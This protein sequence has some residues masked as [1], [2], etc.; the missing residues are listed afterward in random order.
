VPER[1]IISY[2][3]EPAGF[4][5]RVY[6]V[7]FGVVACIVAIFA[8]IFPLPSILEL[9]HYPPGT[10]MRPMGATL[11]I[12]LGAMTGVFFGLPLTALCF[13]LGRRRRGAL[14]VGLAALVLVSASILA[15]YCLFNHIVSSRG[16]ILEP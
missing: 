11:M 4:R 9:L 1:L 8:I 6:A 13:I 15:D 10:S 5:P 2:A 3:S 7:A 14:I 16:Y 12:G